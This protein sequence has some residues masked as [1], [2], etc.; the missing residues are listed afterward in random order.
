MY[1]KDIED[2]KFKDT[3]L[4]EMLRNAYYE[5]Y[6]DS[7]N[8]SIE[9]GIYSPDKAYKESNTYAHIKNYLGIDHF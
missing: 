1:K 2:Y 8:D 9:K 6:I 7:Q 3:A 4:D 5:G